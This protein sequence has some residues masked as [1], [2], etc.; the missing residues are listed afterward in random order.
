MTRLLI[1]VGIVAILAAL[2]AFG[3]QPR[4]ARD[5][6]SEFVG[7]TMNDFDAPLF[8]RYRVEFG[9]TLRYSKYAGNGTPLVVN[10]WASWCVPACW[11]E[12]PR[13]EA[14]W[15]KYQGQILMIGVNFQDEVEDAEEFLDRFGKSYP[16]VRD[17]RGSVGIEW[18]VFGVPET[19]F[20][21]SDGT[22]SYRHNGEISTET[23]EAQIR[24]ILQ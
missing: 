24:A 16:S 19:Y 4:D 22:L 8:E 2:F 13:L 1:V 14:A 12:A 11:N 9:D 23:L 10:F 21:R 6:D 20:I 7:K 3:L 5:L 17:P 15:R 18:G